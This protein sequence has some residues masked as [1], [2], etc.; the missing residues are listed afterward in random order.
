MVNDFG[1]PVTPES[2]D[3]QSRPWGDMYYGWDEAMVLLIIQRLAGI[4]Y[5]LPDHSFT[6]CDHLPEKWAYVEIIVPIVENGK[7]SWTKVRTVR[8]ENDGNITKTV[9]VEGNTQGNLT[10]QPWL[11]NRQLLSKTS[12]VSPGVPMG[13]ADFVFENVKNQSVSIQLGIKGAKQE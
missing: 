3:Q 13:H 7:T 12:D 5:S 9:T 6:V 2:W 4:G 8:T 10:I 1:F 11:E